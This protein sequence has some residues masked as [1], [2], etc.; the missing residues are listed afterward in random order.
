MDARLLLAVR[1][2]LNWTEQWN[3]SSVRPGG[4]QCSRPLFFCR[5]FCSRRSVSRATCIALCLLVTVRS[6]PDK[7]PLH[8][9]LFLASELFLLTPS[10]CFID[11][12]AYLSPMSSKDRFD[13][14]LQALLIK[15]ID[16]CNCSRLLY[17]V[18]NPDTPEVNE[19]RLE[20]N[21]VVPWILWRLAFRFKFPSRLYPW[22]RLQFR[23]NLPE[24]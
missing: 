2:G 19:P 24:S 7:P 22:I 1:L 23:C 11:I 4:S 12:P 9:L 20:A 3:C 14:L 15:Y 13:T 16:S 6:S 17:F 18:S 21:G 5:S 8:F 10:P